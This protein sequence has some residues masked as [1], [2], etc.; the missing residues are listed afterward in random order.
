MMKHVKEQNVTKNGAVKR[1]NLKTIPKNRSN[2][3]I[4]RQVFPVLILSE[5][6]VAS[7]DAKMWLE[8]FD[9]IHRSLFPNRFKLGSKD[10]VWKF[11]KTPKLANMEMNK[12]RR[13]P[14]ARHLMVFL[15][16]SF[17]RLIFACALSLPCPPKPCTPF[18]L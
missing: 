12:T 14:P 2:R 11:L 1:G 18:P 8:V 5:L 17:S 6:F 3:M 9:Q 4:H 15:Q 7:I 16:L 13:R 10:L